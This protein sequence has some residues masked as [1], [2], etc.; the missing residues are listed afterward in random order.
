MIIMPIFQESMRNGKTEQRGRSA[1]S[2]NCSYG[3]ECGRDTRGAG[4][5]GLR[6]SDTTQSL[7]RNFIKIG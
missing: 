6:W 7:E 2:L 3:E 5:S 1:R 4:K